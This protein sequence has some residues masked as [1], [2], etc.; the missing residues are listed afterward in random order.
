MGPFETLT[1]ETREHLVVVS[2]NRPGKL[3]AFDLTMLREL[4]QAYTDYERDPDLWCLLL[5]AHGDHFTAGLDL[6]QVGPAVASGQPL[7][8]DGAVD[9]LDLT[10]PRRTKPVV[11]AVHGW[12]LTIGVEL[13]LAADIRIAAM[14]TRFKQMEVQRGI[15]PFGGGTLRWPQVAGWGNAM[16]WLLTGDEFDAAE[17]MRIGLVQEVV[18]G[19][20]LFE[21]ALWIAERV[22]AQAP[23]AVQATRAS[24][25]TAMEQ[26]PEAAKQGLVDEARRLMGTQDARE[27][28]LSFMERRPARYRGR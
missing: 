28:M 13:C 25:M 24:A 1:V 19:D 2:L 5:V 14:G 21:R 15:M 16:R 7:F 20:L 23:L 10:D 8:P 4:S 22:A 12:C 9:P 18:E 6:A 27:G 3:N 17:A 11:I 26:G